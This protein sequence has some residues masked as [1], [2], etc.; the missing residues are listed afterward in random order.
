MNSNP[1]AVP[2]IVVC[3]LILIACIAGQMVVGVLRPPA[4]GKHARSVPA[5]VI[6]ETAPAD[7]PA[8]CPK[9]G[10]AGCL[11]D[12]AVDWWDTEPPQPPAVEIL[13]GPA[14]PAPQTSA[15]TIGVLARV[16][17]ALLPDAWRPP[18]AEATFTPADADVTCTDLQPIAL[19]RA[20]QA[21]RADVIP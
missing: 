13:T 10:T 21:P 20:E 2:A 9:C 1:Y 4:R 12:E 17:D 8:V 5:A 19:V 18:P 6:P 11:E 3:A 7:A 16:R 15:V 14:A